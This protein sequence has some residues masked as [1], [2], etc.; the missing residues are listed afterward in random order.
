MPRR[1]SLVQVNF[2]V[3]QD[4]LRKLEQEAKRHDRSTNDE[5]AWRLEESFSYADWHEQREQLLLLMRTK[6][7]VQI[8]GPRR[9]ATHEE[10]VEKP[11]RKRFIQARFRLRQEVI[12]KV[13]RE[14]ARHN[15]STNDA[16]GKRLQESFS[17]GDWWEQLMVLMSAL[18]EDVASHP[19]PAATTAAYAKMEMDAEK[20]L[21][22]EIWADL[23]PAKKAKS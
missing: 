10:L 18:I 19:K 20:D 14:A 11:R 16:I 8:E 21:Q 4:I 5:V 23:F 12:R 1:K 22:D 6:L 17:Y 3:R 15:H 7:G 9:H 13:E 2:R